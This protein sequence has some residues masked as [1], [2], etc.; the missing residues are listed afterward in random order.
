MTEQKLDGKWRIDT[1]GFKGLE[2]HIPC[3]LYSALLE[4]GKISDPYYRENEYIST[5]LCDNDAQFRTR[6][7]CGGDLLERK[8]IKLRFNGID[9]CSEITLNG[10]LIGK[11]DNMHCFYE[12]DVKGILKEENDLLVHIFSPNR[13]IAKMQ[14]KRPLWGVDSTMPGYPHIRKAHYMFGWDWGP[15]LP[16]MGIWRSVC[17]LGYDGAR[18]KDVYIMQKHEENKVTLTA[19]VNAD[20]TYDEALMEVFS[21]EGEL[22]GTVR[23]PYADNP[24][25]L[26]FV[27]TDP[28]LWWANGYGEQPLYT[29]KTSLRSGNGIADEKIRR[30][31]LRTLTVSREEDEYGEEFAFVLNGRKI[32]AMGGNIVPE[33]QILPRLSKERTGKLLSDCKDANFNCVRVWGGG[34]YP[35]DFF[36]DICDELGLIVW[37]DFMFACSAYLLTEEFE[38]SVRLEAEQNIIR[39]RNH[40]CLGLW[41][42]NNEIESAW[43]GWG[44]PE[45]EE[46]KSDYLQIFENIIPELLEKYDPDTFYW[47]SSPSSGGGFINSSSNDCGD[48][49]Y[50]DIWH[51]LKPFEEFSKNFGRFC[52]EY[53]FESLPDISTIREFADESKGDFNLTSPVMETHQKCEKGSEKM[54]F[55]LAQTVRYPYGFERLIYSSQ[56][57]QGDC[58]RQNIEAMR[59]ARGKCM[60]S[61]YWQVND[62]NPV[63]S[64]SGI[65][66]YGR[67]KALQYY[68]KRAYAPVLLSADSE[69]VSAVRFNVSNEKL[70]GFNGEIRWALRNNEAEIIKNGN[71]PISVN[72]LSAEYAE[73]VDLSEFLPGRT[74]ITSRYLEYALY[75]NGEKLSGGT[76]LF[77]K[78]KQF[79]FSDPCLKAHAADCRSYWRI[80]V[81]AKRFAYAV[82]PRFENCDAVFEDSWFDIHGG[83][84]EIILRKE[85]LSY[86]FSSADELVSHLVLQS[87]FE[88]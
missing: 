52:S 43:E 5:P 16:D 49:H 72:G 27:I 45:D 39:I 83:E 15:K 47:C 81:S 59:R 33:D 22:I 17:L 11:T 51:G 61:L 10:R 25:A 46:A 36:Y 4:H 55:Y 42:G 74:E 41:C 69:D 23:A 20:G 79:E 73:S 75:E 65:D 53:G 60:G 37:Q 54:M 30:I 88:R 14:E 28:R 62:S 29:V 63:I 80:T 44:L 70:C 78:P 84:Y 48:M 18:I 71:I 85:K 66:Y 19:S 58:I 31:G 40:A 3:S 32:F 26:S 56:L 1:D 57:M 9:S 64:W 6:F 2:T 12:F 13:L 34:Y 68:V 86:D 8:H 77:V 87:A 7:I 76:S 21:P 24:S 50:W 38:N 82:C 35:D 67:Y